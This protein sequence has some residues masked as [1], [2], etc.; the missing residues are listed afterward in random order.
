M[1]LLLYG[2]NWEGTHVDCIS[3]VLVDRNVDH[4]IFDFYKLIY[5]NYKNRILN[6][7]FRE[8]NYSRNEKLVNQLFLKK[9]HE[10]KPDVVLISKGVNIFPETLFEI[11]KSSAQILNWNPD[12]FFNKFNNS[13]HLLS[14]LDLY[15]TVFSARKHLFDE[16]RDKG[17][18]NP[19]YLDWY[20]I[21]WLHKKISSADL[22][23]EKITFIG[24]ISKR[25]E[26]I[27]DAIDER[28]SIE[29]YGS[30]WQYSKLKRKNNITVNQVLKQSD[31]PSIISN[32]RVN[33][34]IITKENR[35]ETNL[36]I[37]E[38][39]ACNGFLLSDYTE[40]SAEIIKQES[41]CCF[42]DFEKKSDLN[43][44]IEKIFGYTKSDYDKIRDSG[45]SR[46]TN[47]HNSIYDKTD[48]ILQYLS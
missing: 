37:F 4:Q 22:T 25:R 2:E 17:I 43:R 8:I 39:T 7:I 40:T 9:F 24:T 23:D 42:Y 1:K 19:V 26:H 27:I 38:I 45:F 6:K 21:P 48:F 33:L 34:N 35:D 41:E 32:S 29:I 11:K 12:D 28:F 10:Y 47:N 30:G 36:K 20:Y 15:D 13:R 31:F 18:K 44:Q 16:Y 5:P 14:S 3:K 46:I